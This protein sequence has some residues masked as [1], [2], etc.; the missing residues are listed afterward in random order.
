MGNDA[1][2]L[3]EQTY[4]A[5]AAALARP[6]VDPVE[7]LHRRGLLRTP[8]GDAKLVVQARADIVAAMRCYDAVAFLR[9]LPTTRP[10]S[11]ADMYDAILGWLEECLELAK[12]EALK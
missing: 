9:R 1:L 6:G 10:A 8:R 12:K 4:A 7:E 2:I 5:A 11:P 3:D